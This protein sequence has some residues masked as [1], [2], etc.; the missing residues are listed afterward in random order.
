MV[1]PFSIKECMFVYES[2][3]GE[4]GHLWIFACYFFI[5][6]LEVI[7]FTDCKQCLLPLLWSCLHIH[8]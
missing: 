7:D 3:S 5:L 6:Y 8:K 4:E 2:S 1:D